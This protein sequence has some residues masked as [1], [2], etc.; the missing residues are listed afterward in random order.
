[1]AT[2]EP[3]PHRGPPPP[4]RRSKISPSSLGWIVLTLLLAGL[5]ILAFQEPNQQQLDLAE[6][7]VIFDAQG[8][9]GARG[10]VPENTLPGFAEALRI[11]VHTLELDVVVTADGVPVVLHDPVLNPEQTRGPDGGWLT[12]SPLPVG[13]LTLEQLKRYDVGRAKPGSRTAERFPEQ[14]GRDGVTIPTLAEVIALAEA[15]S[16][17]EARYNIETK[18]SPEHPGLTPAPEAFA[19]AVIAVLREAGVIERATVQSFDWRTLQRVQVAEPEL[20]TA[21]LTAERDWLDNIRRD[22]A[23]GSPWLAGHDIEDAEGLV[24]VLVDRA[25]GDIWSPYYR[26]LRE[27]DLRD[28]HKLG[29]RVIVWTVND[30][31]DMASLI[32]LGVDGII[33]DYPDRLKAVLGDYGLPDPPAYPRGS[34]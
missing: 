30:P 26:D 12:G 32:E 6:D 15:Q 19:E 7:Y 25:G 27:V 33:T 16:G 14:Q 4:Q 17:G 13:E 29:L 11:G 5:G 24:P 2:R 8:H 21:Y 9:R 10:L 20:T 18:I 28:A 23:G 3:P 31:D 22:E 34:D 1:M